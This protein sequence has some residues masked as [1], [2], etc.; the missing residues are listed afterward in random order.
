MKYLNIRVYGM[1]K[2]FKMKYRVFIIFKR[3]YIIYFG[4]SIK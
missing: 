2:V 3:I 4:N 1:E